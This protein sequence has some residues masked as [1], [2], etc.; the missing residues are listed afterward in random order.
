[1]GAHYK[2]LTA[3]IAAWTAGDIEGALAFMADNIEWHYAAAVAPP[4]RGKDKARKFLNRFAT[5]ARD[6]R[7]RI[8]HYAEA[9]DRLFV[10]G[11]DE[12]TTTAGGRVV[13]PYAGVLEFKDGLIAGWRDYVDVGVMEAMRAGGVVPAHIEALIDHPVAA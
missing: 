11:V 1:M 8:F 13:A 3:L 2:T 10:E 5:E 4:L 7:W 9:G 12:F 6:I